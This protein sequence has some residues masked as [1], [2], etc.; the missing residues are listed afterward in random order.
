MP[1]SKSNKITKGVDEEL[2]YEDEDNFDSVNLKLRK[3]Q[4][5]LKNCQKEKQEYL[6]GWQRIKADFI[7]LKKQSDIDRK[8]M[9]Q[10]ANEEFITE[11]LPALDSFD[12]A[13]KNKKKWEQVEESWRTGVEFIHSQLLKVMK[14]YDVKEI[15][16]L[17]E[18]FDPVLHHSSGVVR[19]ENKKDDGKIVEV[20][21]KGYALRDKI[22]RYPNV[23]V[24]EI[25]N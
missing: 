8:K 3:I 4:K 12:H 11:L 23:K 10:Y 9:I 6:D 20:I 22:I 7:N 16:P 13:F 1:K 15:A 14:D 25:N 2:I 5:E 24:G 19:V 21:Q 17:G 18:E